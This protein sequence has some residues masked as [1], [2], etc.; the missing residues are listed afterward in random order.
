MCDLK[1]FVKDASIAL[2]RSTI[3][4]LLF[5]S[6]DK[7]MDDT[8]YLITEEKQTIDILLATDKHHIYKKVW[9]GI[10][11]YLYEEFAP[12]IKYEFNWNLEITPYTLMLCKLSPL[13]F[14]ENEQIKNDLTTIKMN[15]VE[16]GANFD[17][18]ITKLRLSDSF[19]QITDEIWPGD[20]LEK[21]N[22]LIRVMNFPPLTELAI[23]Y[24]KTYHK[25]KNGLENLFPAFCG[26]RKYTIPDFS[27]A[28]PLQYSIFSF[29]YKVFQEKGIDFLINHPSLS[30]FKQ[31]LEE[32]K[33]KAL[34]NDKKITGPVICQCCGETNE[35]TVPIEIIQYKLILENHHL[36]NSIGFMFH[37]DF[38]VNFQ[39]TFSDNYFG[40]LE[41]LNNV[42]KPDCIILVEGDSEEFAI[43][44]LAFRKRF[45]LA[46]HNV[47]VHN[48][49]S[50]ERVASDFF[51]IKKKHPLTKII[52]L[53]DSDALKEKASIERVIKD[54]KNQYRL[55]FINKGTFEDI[56]PIA[57]S[58]SILNELF[59]EG[60]L[61][62]ESDFAEGKD[63]LSNIKKALY[64]K[65]KATFDKVKFAKKISLKIDSDK[66]PQI[67]DD[68]I[69]VAGSFTKKDSI[70][71]N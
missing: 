22:F 10:L 16:F 28:Y 44:I 17:D 71:K 1:P 8:L 32:I 52:C 29:N 14:D 6:F 67:I 27:I 34:I 3:D 43:P 18:T 11:E 62:V 59:P 13:S 46:F 20:K 65:K 21:F 54:K 9:K 5:F 55:M 12:W 25:Y 26:E 24:S 53:L 60:D 30:L 19:S 4:R 70:F 68:I 66:I 38:I 45:I 31:V 49:T 23:F 36:S 61:I 69:E 42:E 58:V 7:M 51:S 57:F 37:N 41:N 56:F 2:I 63:F 50:K 40:F 15:L 64:Q 39:N 48:S 33:Q 35:A 47:F